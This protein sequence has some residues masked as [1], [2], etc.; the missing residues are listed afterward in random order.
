LTQQS[1][2]MQK[3]LTQNT[4]EIQDTM[5]RPNLSIIG[6]D[7]KG[8]FQLKGPIN[9]FNKI[10]EENFPNLN[11]EMPVNTQEAYRTPNSLDQKRNS[12]HHIII[13][14]PNAQNK[15]RILKAVREKG[16]VTYKGRPIRITPDFSPETMKARRPWAD[17]IQTPREHKCQPRLLYH[18]KLSITR[19]GET[20]FTQDLSTN[21]A[22]QRIIKGKLQHKEG[23]YALEK[24]TK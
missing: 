1:K 5:R 11:K 4:Q 23:N 16:Q 8:D 24:A 18:A 19:D 2:K 3:I 9:I 14:T 22:L 10:I 6:I 7:K 15:E 21:R 17:V 12:S 13:K 20:K